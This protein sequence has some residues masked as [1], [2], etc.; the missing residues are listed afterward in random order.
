MKE[1]RYSRQTL[2]KPIGEAGQERL[3]QKH[4][5][6]VGAGALG[7]GIA[8]PLVRAGVG[9][10]TIVDRDYVEW[11]N[12]QRQ[13]LYSERDAEK[14]FPKAIAA[15]RR[16]E[17]INSEVSIEAK[18]QDM[19][20]EEFEQLLPDVDL[21]MDATDNFET[22]LLMNDLA[23]KFLTPWIYG[24][25]VGSHGMSYTIMPKEM[26]CLNCLMETVPMG[27]ATCDTVGVIGPVVQMVCAHQVAEALKILVGDFGSLHRKF[28]TFDLWDH[29]YSGISVSQLK[30]SDCPSCGE[31][32]SYPFLSYENRSKSA[33]LCGRDTV[34]IRPGLKGNRDLD[35]LRQR[36]P[37][38]LVEQNAF[39]LSYEHHGHRMVFFSDG[40][41]FI[42][43]TKDIVKAKSLYHSV[44]GG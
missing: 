21:M 18:V 10:I 3:A 12:L 14:R 26:P 33:V 13:Q 24:A 8:E 1:D 15:K 19:Q 30:R 9:K 6:I 31:D 17:E 40:R 34:Q 36:L 29:R 5:L 4:V 43:G 25:C 7:T 39:L 41:V 11:S 35:E 44:V 32:P 42:H 20:R 2:F 38:H 28:I 23:Q 37:D 22:R 27:G 16:L